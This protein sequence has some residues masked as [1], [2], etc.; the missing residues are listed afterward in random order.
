MPLPPHATIYESYTVYRLLG[1]KVLS[2]KWQ[3]LYAKA[4]SAH[5]VGFLLTRR[6]LPVSCPVFGKSIMIEGVGVFCECF[7][8]VLNDSIGTTKLLPHC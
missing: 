6:R 4:A 3:L 2:H 5:F 1:C 8:F 7:E